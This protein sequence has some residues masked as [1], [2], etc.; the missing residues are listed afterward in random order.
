M[1]ARRSSTRRKRA[2]AALF[3]ALVIITLA[4]NTTMW[5][6]LES[7]KD[8]TLLL[9]NQNGYFTSDDGKRI[10]L[11]VDRDINGPIEFTIYRVE[12]GSGAETRA[13]TGKMTS[14]GTLW[15]HKYLGAN[16]SQVR[17]PGTY[18][19][20]L[21]LP[22][23]VTPWTLKTYSSN[24]FVVSDS[25][26]D[27]TIDLAYKFFY[28]Q[29]CGQAVASIVSGYP[30]H[31]ACHLDDANAIS[32]PDN[33]STWRN[34]TGGWH[35]AGDYNKYNNGFTPLSIYALAEAYEIDPGFFNTTTRL[36]TY[37]DT[38]MSIHHSPSVPD[39][40][41]EAM[42]GADWVVKC[43]NIDGS[44][45]ADV[46]SDPSWYGYWGQPQLETDNTLG[47]GIDNRVYRDTA[48]GPVA[49]LAAAAL[50]KLARILQSNGWHTGHVAGYIDAAQR[51]VN[52]YQ[53]SCP[54]RIETLALDLELCALEGNTSY[55]V[56]ATRIASSILSN[57]AWIED[58][59]FSHVGQDF[60][61]YLLWKWSRVNGTAEATNQLASAFNMH[62]HGF[63]SP[64]SNPAVASNL[65]GILRGRH[66]GRGEFYFWEWT[67]GYWN[68]GQNS[69][70][71]SAAA[72]AAAAY[73][74]TREKRYIDFTQRQLDWVLGLNPFGICMLEGAGEKNLPN[75]HNRANTIPGNPRGAAPGCVP[76][77]IVRALSYDPLDPAPD[78]PY[79]DTFPTPG[80]T[81]R[82][83]SNEPWLPHNAYY[84]LA[85]CM[86]RACMHD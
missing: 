2:R 48:G 79:L 65:F 44:M 37:P 23:P 20:R 27:H 11:Q 6:E 39:I 56:D 59:N 85:A 40:I 19:A 26:L 10:L 22:D 61:F 1:G 38:A 74:L 49:V 54:D 34:L 77:G 57:T 47:T 66:V 9:V 30:G 50:V 12:P 3:L 69:Y 15:G 32:D 68:V 67:A 35:D 41:E 72:A 80:Y 45:I 58:P 16:I 62:W 43:V 71:L 70:Y 8:T 25:V 83:E 17:I 33:A 63:W 28:Y 14:L 53:A 5:Y 84:L 4:A 64:L 86:T 78:E 18:I 31:G 55:L 82:Y 73:N 81:P 60:T 13:M 52:Y 7:R 29:R 36:A 75:Y 21:Q 46:G 42:W 51:I 24:S 76:N